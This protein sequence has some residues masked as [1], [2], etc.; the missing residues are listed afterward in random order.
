MR[1]NCPP[2]CV[3]IWLLPN[4]KRITLLLVGNYRKKTMLLRKFCSMKFWYFFQQ[5]NKAVWCNQFGYCAAG[6]L[7]AWTDK[8]NAALDGYL[9][10]FQ[11]IVL[12]FSSF[13]T[14]FNIFSVVALDDLLASLPRYS[15]QI[16][17]RK[18]LCVLKNSECFMDVLKNDRVHTI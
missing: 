10:R 9:Q 4:T 13:E 6:C 15:L 11:L 17:T 12:A 5:Q 3:Q 1:I 2:Q 14:F 18:S 7:D 16:A 8:L